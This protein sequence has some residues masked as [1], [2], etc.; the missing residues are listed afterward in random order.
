MKIND[1]ISSTRD[2]YTAL[3]SSSID[4]VCISAPSVIDQV[5]YLNKTSWKN[6]VPIQFPVSLSPS[7]LV[8]CKES[9]CFKWLYNIEQWE[10]WA[11]DLHPW[12]HAKIL[13]LSRYLFTCL[14]VQLL[15]SYYVFP[16]YI[17]MHRTYLKK[18]KEEER[19]LVCL[20]FMWTTCQSILFWH[21]TNDCCR[22]L[23]IWR[24]RYFSSLA[25]LVKLNLS[26]LQW[27]IF[28]HALDAYKT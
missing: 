14:G 3:L 10:H 8:Q 23:N 24:T 16:R 5:N 28:I 22:S 27:Q 21:F 2:A 4:N 20:S 15:R 1:I 18:K 25:S 11:A 12:W 13:F 19:S 6:S 26:F 9:L 7:I 17:S